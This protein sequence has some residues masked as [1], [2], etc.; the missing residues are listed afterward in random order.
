MILAARYA[1]FILGPAYLS[2]LNPVPFFFFVCL[3]LNLPGVYRA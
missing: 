2:Y 3:E 1:T